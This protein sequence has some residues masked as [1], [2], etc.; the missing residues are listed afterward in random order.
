MFSG[1]Q[2]VHALSTF[3][4][5]FRKQAEGSRQLACEAQPGSA[6]RATENLPGEI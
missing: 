4:I 2:L 5:L 1:K 6:A 3:L